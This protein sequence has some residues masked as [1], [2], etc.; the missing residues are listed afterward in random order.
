MRLSL[1]ATLAL[2]TLTATAGA[3]S[4]WKEIG[5]TSSGNKVSVDPHSVKRTGS[6]VAATVRVVFSPPVQ[7]PKGPWASAQT[8]ATFDCGKRLLAAKE[9]AYF[10]DVRGGKLT[11]RKVNKVPGYGPALKGSLGEVAL[12][13]L[14]AR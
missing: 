8:K 1:A 11:E 14:C 6:L 10:A 2:A 7:T 4:R 12:T 3:Q 5:T 13:W 9:N